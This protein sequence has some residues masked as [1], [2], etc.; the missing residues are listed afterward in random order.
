MALVLRSWYESS[1]TGLVVIRFESTMTRAQDM[2]CE[3]M[4]CETFSHISHATEADWRYREQL[5][6]ID[7]LLSSFYFIN[8]TPTEVSLQPDPSMWDLINY[9]RVTFVQLTPLPAPVR[10]A[11]HFA[12]CIHICKSIEQI[13]CGTQVKKLTKAGLSNFKRNLDALLDFIGTISIQQLR[14]CFSALTQLVE[15][16]LSGEVD[17]FLDPHQR[18]LYRNAPLA[19]TPRSIDHACDVALLCD[20]ERPESTRICPWR[21]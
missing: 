6:K 18:Y 7:E 20:I 21:L 1:L 16:F 8:W 14:E 4:V 12:S 11:V 2:V 9:L 5:K 15:L 10:E 19:F 17:K 3:L 13:L